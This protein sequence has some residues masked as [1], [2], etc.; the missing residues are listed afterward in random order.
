MDLPDIQSPKPEP[1]RPPLRVRKTSHKIRKPPAAPP[2]AGEAH[3]PPPPVIIYTEDPK[4]INVD[5]HEFKSV[6]QRLTGLNSSSSSSTTLNLSPPPSS[7][8]AFQEN[9]GDI[10]PP[11]SESGS[12]SNLNENGLNR[13]NY[14]IR[15][16]MNM[17]NTSSPKNVDIFSTLFDL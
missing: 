1:R 15:P 17:M 12:H 6:V 5:P 13:A 2:P 8:A 4:I 14:F 10:F 3:P 9:G 11:S 16:S 7:A